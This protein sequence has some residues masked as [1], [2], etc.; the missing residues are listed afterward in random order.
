[1]EQTCIKLSFM[2]DLLYDNEKNP[3]IHLPNV[4]VFTNSLL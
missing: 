2:K 1:M 3:H 4:C